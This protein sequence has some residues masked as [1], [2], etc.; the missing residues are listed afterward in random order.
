MQRSLKLYRRWACETISANSHYLCS[1]ML[2]GS[3]K[4][5]ALDENLILAY[6]L[7][8]DAN[9]NYN[10]NGE[11]ERMLFLYERAH[12]DIYYLKHILGGV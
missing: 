5:R 3:S 2:E 6:L 12:E 11:E 4:R 7:E 10:R 1:R 8:K 9:A